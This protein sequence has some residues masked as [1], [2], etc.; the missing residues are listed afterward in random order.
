MLPHYG[1][2][3]KLLRVA[4]APQTNNMSQGAILQNDNPTQYTLDIGV[5]VA[6][7]LQ[8]SGTLT[9]LLGC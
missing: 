8:I 5:L 2:I 4:S 3:C 9:I 6:I 1:G 7:P